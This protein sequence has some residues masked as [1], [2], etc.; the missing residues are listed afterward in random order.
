MLI[1]YIGVWMPAVARINDTSDHGGYI[2]S[3]TTTKTFLDS[4]S[5]LVAR[6]GDLHICPIPG[7][8]I[9]P[10]VNGSGNFL[11]ESKVTAVVGSICGCGA[12][13]NSGSST[14][15]APLESPSGALALG[16]GSL[17]SSILG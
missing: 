10:I 11:C 15:T 3:V 13:I 1:Q 9:T 6:V 2:V 14:V 5:R 17:G 12:R 4:S 7:H 8:G 16:S